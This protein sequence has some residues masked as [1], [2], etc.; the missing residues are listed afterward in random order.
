LR[1]F[2]LLIGS[3]VSRAHLLGPRAANDALGARLRRA[4][5]A[6]YRKCSSSALRAPRPYWTGLRLHSIGAE[7]AGWARLELAKAAGSD[8]TTEKTRWARTRLGHS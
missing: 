5:V 1:L 3:A 8:F 2:L 4:V 7:V 6:G